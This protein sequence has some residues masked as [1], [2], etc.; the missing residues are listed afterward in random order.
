MKEKKTGD[1]E[2]EKKEFKKIVREVKIPE[3]ISIQELSNRMAEKSSDLIKFLMGNLQDPFW[4][5]PTPP[6]LCFN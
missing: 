2:T 4:R 1:N 3:R 5:L 6:S